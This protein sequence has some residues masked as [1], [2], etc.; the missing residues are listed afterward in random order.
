[1]SLV[2][3]STLLL[4]CLMKCTTELPLSTEPRKKTIKGH[5]MINSIRNSVVELSRTHAYNGNKC[6][7]FLY[8]GTCG[9]ANKFTMEEQELDSLMDALMEYKVKIV[10][11]YAQ[12]S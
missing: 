10:K 7:S 9:A 8:I 5:N 6:L 1:M 3:R 2:N 4:Y 11:K 12:T